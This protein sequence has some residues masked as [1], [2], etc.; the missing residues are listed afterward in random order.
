[1]LTRDWRTD[2][3]TTGELRKEYE[4][5]FNITLGGRPE[6]V[7]GGL[8]FYISVEYLED[9][10]ETN[11]MYRV[12]IEREIKDHI[13][14]SKLRCLKCGRPLDIITTYDDVHVQC[15]NYS[16][17]AYRVRTE[18]GEIYHSAGD[19]ESVDRTVEESIDLLK[20]YYGDGIIKSKTIK[21]NNK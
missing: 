17:H 10:L 8:P 4:D 2:C 21:E 7:L 13:D 14:L 20:Y 1:M 6:I 16:C 12:L 11:P 3:S 19:L 18:L 15:F 9:I 5:R